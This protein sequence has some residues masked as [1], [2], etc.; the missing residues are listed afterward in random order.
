[1][2]ESKL[3]RVGDSTIVV[4]F[5]Q[6]IDPII[7]ARVLALAARIRQTVPEGVRDIIESYCAVTV[8][9]DPLRTDIDHVIKLLKSKI[10]EQEVAKSSREI[11]LPICYGGEYGPD[12]ECVAKFAKCSEAEVIETHLSRDYLVYMLGFRPG[13]AY[14]GSVDSRIAIPR[15]G[16]PR[17]R[18]P[19]GSVGLAGHQ[20]GI[21]PSA[22]PGGWH[23]IGRSPATLFDPESNEPFLLRGGDVVSFKSITR[24]E[25]SDRVGV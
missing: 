17:L 23:L 16:T 13:F 7:H 8:E 3:L 20:T 19:I 24:Q 2:Q 12:L 18:V 11:T 5:P 22:G 14:M 6:R 21:Y 9:F 10:E 1:M 4:E 25:F 15:R